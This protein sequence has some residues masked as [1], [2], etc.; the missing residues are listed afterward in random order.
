MNMRKSAW[1][2]LMTGILVLFAGCAATSSHK[3]CSNGGG[4]EMFQ[5]HDRHLRPVAE[6]RGVWLRPPDNPDEILQMLDEI[7]NAGFNAIFLETLYHGFAIFPGSNFPLRPGYENRDVLQEFIA[8]AHQRGIAV[9]CWTEVFYWQVDTLKHPKLPHSPILDEKPQWLLLTRDGRKTDVA[10]DAHIFADPANPEVQSFLLDFYR[11]LVTRYDVDGVNLDYIRYSAGDPDAGYTDIARQTFKK[12]YGSDP[13]TIN[14]Q[15]DP[16]LWMSWVQWREDRITEFVAQISDMIRREN[17]RTVISAAIFPGYYSHRGD[18]STYQNCA[19]WLDKNHVDVMIPMAYAAS[20][21]DIRNEI[22]QVT[23]RNSGY[24]HVMPALAIS[25]QQADAYSSTRSPVIA[26]Q[27][28]MV[29]GMG[30][31]GHS[32]FCYSWIL[33]NEQRFD[34]FKEIYS[35]ST[36][37]ILDSFPSGD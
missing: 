27:I 6:L 28:N 1:V 19:S 32:I 29:R 17:P 16:E 2:L 11:D 5:N 30:L 10:E 22:S 35:T 24:A 31:K 18:H 8:G 14:P 7:K 3:K 36:W 26:E 21:D 13:I 25:V 33:Q 34:N 9:H 15:T 12:Q 37:E 20:L 4:P 23:S